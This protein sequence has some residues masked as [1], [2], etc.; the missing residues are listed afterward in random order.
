M[1]HDWRRSHSVNRIQSRQ[2][3]TSWSKFLTTSKV[4]VHGHLMDLPVGG[5]SP[6]L[7]LFSFVILSS[8][9]LSFY[10][11]DY[12][13]YLRPGTTVLFLLGDVSSRWTLDRVRD[14]QSE[15]SMRTHDL[16][17]TKSYNFTTKDSHSRQQS[18]RSSSC[19]TSYRALFVDSLRCQINRST[20]FGTRS[21]WVL[22]SIPLLLFTGFPPYF[23]RSKDLRKRLWRTKHWNLF[24]ER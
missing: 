21:S 17:K 20:L 5:W 24:S 6:G 10:T 13:L 12:H 9:V 1:C 16:S 7:D 19:H 22:C 14:V 11:S 18:M 8:L 15:T 2:G 3:E 23:C 4:P